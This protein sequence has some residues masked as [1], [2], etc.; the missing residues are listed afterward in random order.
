METLSHQRSQEIIWP[1]HRGYYKVYVDDYQIKRKISKWGE[2][3]LHCHYYYPDGKNA[4][5]FI[6]PSK[7]YNRAADELGLPRKAKN[8]NRIKCGKKNQKQVLASRFTG[9]K[10]SNLPSTGLKDKDSCQTM[11]S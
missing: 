6:I 10:F 11:T 4:W 7:L 3:K 5:D 8:K 1:W 2:A 9:V